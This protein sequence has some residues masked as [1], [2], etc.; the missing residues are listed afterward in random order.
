[1]Y[2]WMNGCMYVWMYVRMYV[3]MHVLVH[4]EIHLCKYA[5]ICIIYIYVINYPNGSMKSF[6]N[7][8]ADM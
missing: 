6:G 5:I 2:G 7:T 8:A 3:C 4:E 1:M